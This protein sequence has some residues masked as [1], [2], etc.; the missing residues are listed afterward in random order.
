MN[1]IYGSLFL[2]FFVLIGHAQPP[3]PAAITDSLKK[4]ASMVVRQDDLEIE[5]ISPRKAKMHHRYVY[6]ILNALGDTYATVHTFYDPFHD[7]V[8]ASGILYDSEGR[9]LKKIRKSDMQDV[10]LAGNGILMSDTRVKFYSFGWR[11]YPYTISYEE[12]VNLNG[13]FQLPE[14]LPQPSQ[15]VAMENCS[16]TIKAPANYPLR[17]KTYDYPGE[18]PIITT[19]KDQKTYSWQYK[20]H[21]AHHPE[22]Y[23]PAWR[24]QETRVRLVPASFELQGFKGSLYSWDDIGK[25]VMT[26]YRGRDKLPDECKQKV[27]QLTD[28]LTDDRQK[29]VVLYK[30]LQQNTHYVG[31][32]LG[33][34]GWQPYDAEYVYTKRYGDCKALSNYMVA[35]LKEAGIRAANVL[36]SGGIEPPFMD[37]SFACPRFNHAIVVA[38][39]GKDSVWLESTSQLLAPG[40]LGAFTADRDG[41]LLDPAGNSH[42]VHTPVYGAVQNQVRHLVNGHID[43]QGSLTADLAYEYSGLEQDWLQ[44]MMDR[45]TPKEQVAERQQQLGIHNARITSLTHS[46]DTS[47]SIPAIRENIQLSVE[48]FATVSGNR[49]ML[50][51][52]YFFKGM[53]PVREEAGRE[54]SFEL[55]QSFEEQD[56]VVLQVPPGYL[57]ESAP[58]SASFSCPC[59]SYRIHSTFSDGVFVISCHFRQNKGLYPAS[60]WP[61]MARFFNLVHREGDRQLVFIKK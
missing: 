28:G 21:A 3:A 5:I 19:E 31:I 7:L 20:F 36:I 24:R 59:G 55:A 41:L 8:S 26:L 27:H 10:N 39:T 12:E 2:L 9:P 35:M 56:S 1:K 58:F 44:S 60:L 54:H 32:E 42:I 22:L 23:E 43:T 57:P 30:F 45:L 51:P 49:L 33:I 6:T 14:W 37:T 29:I 4:N 50:Y 38:F 13:L 61:R 46:A 25:F 18:T 15:N 53:T 11:T 34:G 48:S 52:G 47:M 40:Y 16:L 17:Y